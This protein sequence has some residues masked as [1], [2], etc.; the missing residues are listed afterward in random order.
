MCTHTIVDAVDSPGVT[1]NIVPLQRF[2]GVRKRVLH[3][4]VHLEVRYQTAK[5][6]LENGEVGFVDFLEDTEVGVGP[7]EFIVL[8]ARASIQSVV[9][10]FQAKSERFRD[11]EIEHM[12]DTSGGRERRG[13]NAAMSHLFSYLDKL[14]K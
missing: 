1:A 9:P 11:F 10:F 13:V 12:Q 3:F 6:G 7:T 4:C 8:R 2:G 14:N 5:Q